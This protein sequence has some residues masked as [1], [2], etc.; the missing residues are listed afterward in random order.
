MKW[1]IGENF[2]ESFSPLAGYHT[3]FFT[4]DEEKGR[5]DFPPE[6]RKFDRGSIVDQAQEAAGSTGKLK[7]FTVS[8]KFFSGYLSTVGYLK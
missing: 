7:G 6:G 2:P 4:P 3:V 5:M 1:G 8:F